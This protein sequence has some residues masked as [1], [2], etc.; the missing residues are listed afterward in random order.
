MKPE[1]DQSIARTEFATDVW[2]G[3]GASPKTLSS[4]W[5]YDQRGSELY[6][7]IT[8]VPEYYPART[9][10]GILHERKEDIATF[11]AGHPVLLE[12]G[13]GAS[14]KTELLLPAL[15][16]LQWY[17]P[18]DIAGDFLAQTARRLRERF[19]TLQIRPVV[20]DF[21][22]PFD[23]P[24]DIP[25]SGRGAFFPGSTIGNLDPTAAVAFLQR[26]GEHVG[27]G[28]RAV[29][30]A[31]LIKNL[32]V[33][34]AAYDDAAGIT[35]EFN[36]NLLRRI[37]RELK[38]NFKLEN[39]RHEARWNAAESAIEMHLT[40]NRAQ[41]VQVAGRNFHFADGESLHTESS[42]K[43]DMDS[44]TA[45]AHESGWRIATHWTD[46]RDYFALF[47]LERA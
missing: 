16:A 21:T 11:L 29:I 27:P 17:V 1:S 12:Y 23:L 43:Y 44:F 3:L 33:L 5:L 22:Q 40:S 38:G 18:I 34:L 6:E 25:A 7:E 14:V 30:G 47:G 24:H 10:T 8:Q 19:P 37:N 4:R 35:A 32:E 13:A 36:R 31:D 28:G 42:R 45:L 15:T 20:A 9:E 26:V 2:H 46:S 41:T 39:F